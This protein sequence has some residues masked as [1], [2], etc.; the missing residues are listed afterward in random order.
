[1]RHS[2]FAFLFLFMFGVLNAQAQAQVAGDSC[3][4]DLLGSVTMGEYQTLMCDGTNYKLMVE[5]D[6]AGR[7]NLQIDDDTA[8]VCDATKLGRLA[9]DDGVDTWQYCDGSN[10]VDLV[11]AAGSGN[12]PDFIV[13]PAKND[14]ALLTQINSG[15]YPV[16]GLSSSAATSIMG[17]GSPQYR[18]CDDMFCATVD[19]SW[20]SGSSTVDADQFVQI[21]MASGGPNSSRTAFLTVGDGG[22][23]WQLATAVTDDKVVFTT[24]TRYSGALGGVA[25]ADTKCQTHASSAGM[26]GTF[27]AWIS[28]N[29]LSPSTTFSQ[30]SGADYILIDGT[31]IANGW[32]DL[33]DGT[34]D[35]LL[36]LDENGN[37]IS[38]SY[39]WTNTNSNG[40][41]YTT[42]FNQSCDYWTSGTG[43]GV[44]TARRGRASQ[45]SSQWTSYNVVGCNNTYVLYCF[46]Q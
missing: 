20:T 15:V 5:T 41:I 31:I 29:T 37:A 33:T 10:W 13:L 3:A 4:G 44:R 14:V 36:N 11:S 19:V 21:R 18:I 9:Y 6:T 46:E 35:N 25:G 34:L 2:L 39:S 30:L 40:S 42:G 24:S 32:S 12:A 28:D 7:S 26:L 1:M 22:F 16:V 17:P 38:G 8:N 43:G 23:L 45:T 27:K